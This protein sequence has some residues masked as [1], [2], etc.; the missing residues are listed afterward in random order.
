MA[1]CSLL[2]K[3][4]VTGALAAGSLGLPPPWLMP[5]ATARSISTFRANVM[6]RTG[7]TTRITRARSVLPEGNQPQ[8]TTLICIRPTTPHICSTRRR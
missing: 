6:T 3:G 5:L 1:L 7:W 8:A 2:V 4:A